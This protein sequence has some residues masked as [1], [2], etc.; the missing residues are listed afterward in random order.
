MGGKSPQSQPSPVLYDIY[1][2]GKKKQEESSQKSQKICDEIGGLM[3]CQFSQRVQVF[4]LPDLCF[5]P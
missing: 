5:T 4:P 1:D 3:K 2:G